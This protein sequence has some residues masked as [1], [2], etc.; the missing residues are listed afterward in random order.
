MT[1][2]MYMLD[3]SVLV[4]ILRSRADS[5]RGRLN[6]EPGAPCMSV[7]TLSELEVGVGKSRQPETARNALA[8]LEAVIPVVPFETSH[9]RVYG[10]LRAELE[11]RGRVIGPLDML[12]AA[13]ALGLGCRLITANV[14]EFERVDGLRV[15]VWM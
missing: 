10:G 9:A 14:R 15:E 11:R 12:I 5:L 13:H 7:V 2:S 6:S 3:T 1:T 8:K 4:E